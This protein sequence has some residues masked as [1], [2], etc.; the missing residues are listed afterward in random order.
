MVHDQLWEDFGVGEGYLCW[1][2]FEKR[3]GRKLQKEDLT[4]VV[5]NLK[6]NP[7]VKITN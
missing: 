6:V 5:C 3:L 4:E 7:K 2:C 1:D